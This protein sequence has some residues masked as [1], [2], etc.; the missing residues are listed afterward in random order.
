MSL[1]V[2]ALLAGALAAP[3]AGPAPAGKGGIAV[4]AGDVTDRR[5]NDNV[6]SSLEIELKLTGEASAG[7]RGARATVEKA[8]DDTGRNL[9][10][11][12]TDSDDFVKSSGD[13]P[14]A[15]KVELRNPARR[16]R[17]VREVSGRLEVFL[18]DRD[19]ASQARVAKFASQLDRPVSAPALKA[20]GAQVTVV[21]RKTYEAEKK[22]DAERR[23]KE[24]EGA[25][26]AGAMVNAFAG[27]FEGLFGD[28]GENDVLVRVDDKGKKVF[29]IDVLDAAGKP[30]DGMGSMTVGEFWILKFADKLPADAALRIYVLT[31]KAVVTERFALKDVALP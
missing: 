11:E 23:K 26:I 19:P 6:F 25:G 20:A 5:R 2:I 8:V 27:L 4:A 14:P 30:V 17:T 31:P 28:I 22:K 29:S 21:S 7:A 9:I 18:P 15:L 24:A 12:R 16:A 3:A 1:A 10:K 13:G